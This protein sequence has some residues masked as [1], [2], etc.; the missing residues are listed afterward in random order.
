MALARSENR[1]FGDSAPGKA[2]RRYAVLP[3]ADPNTPARGIEVL[4]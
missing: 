3:D 2:K 1:R 4:K